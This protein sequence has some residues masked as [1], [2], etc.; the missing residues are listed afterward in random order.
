[1]LNQ[2]TAFIFFLL[3]V[4]AAAS[5][6]VEIKGGEYKPLYL[7]KDSQKEIIKDF[8]LDK[9][10]V[11]NYDYWQFVK[12]NPQW[13]K[14]KISS[15]LTENQYLHHWISIN[16]DQESQEVNWQ[17]TA[18]DL[19]KPVTNIS[20]FAAQAYCQSQNKRLPKVAEWEYVA[21]ASETHINGKDE[22]NYNQRILNWYSKPNTQSLSEV[23]STSKNYWGVYDMHGLIWE[24]TEDFNST[25]INGESRNDSV[26]DTALYCGAGSS[27]SIDPSDYAAFMRFGFRSSLQAK[28]TINNLGFRCA[29]SVKNNIEHVS[30]NTQSKLPEDSIY[31]LEGIWSNQDNKKIQ[32]SDLKGKKR[33]ISLIYTRCPST[34]PIIV[35]SLQ[36]I[37]KR[38]DKKTLSTLGFVLISLTPEEDTPET[39]KKFAINR[40][41]NLKHWTILTGDSSQTRRL[42]MALNIKYKKTDNNEVAHSNLFTLV[43]EQGRVIFQEIAS[44]QKADEVVNKVKHL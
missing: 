35:S 44:M 21:A 11:T 13:K 2:L 39:L 27:G 5:S 16:N 8:Q 22:P 3:A 10:P 37:E 40:K 18:N 30:E 17:P 20:W 28:F 36:A 32:L 12:K 1:M 4:T 14:Q 31:Q 38:L 7:S 25:L 41:L 29:S 43:D 19:N 42:A 33:L 15:L 23:A 26:L 34:C 6:M 9:T 24:W